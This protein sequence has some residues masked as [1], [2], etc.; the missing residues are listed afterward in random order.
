MPVNTQHKLYQKHIRKWTTVRDC[1]D[2]QDAIKEKGTAYLPRSAAHS[3]IEYE[4]YKERAAFFDGTSRTAEGLH[5]HLFAEDPVQSGEISDAFKEKLKNIDASGTSLDQF[6]SNIC[7]DAM[8]APW[9]GVLVDHIPVPE[10]STL[11]DVSGG[12]FLKWYPAESLINWNHSTINGEK[13]LTMVVLREDIEEKKPDDEFAMDTIEAYRV[14]SLD[15]DGYYNQ[16][17]FRKAE[18]AQDKNA[19]FV[20]TSIIYPKMSG[21][22]FKYIPFY[23]CPGEIPEKSM[24]LGLAYENIGYYQKTAEYENGLYFTS[25]PT[26]IVENMK[27]PCEEVE[28]K[29]KED[30]VEKTKKEK[31]YKKVT[32]GGSKFLFFYQEDK[33]GKSADVRVKFLEFDGAGL[34]EIAKALNS[35]LDRMAKLGI[36]AIGADKKGVET[37][38]VAQIHRASEHGVLGA[39]ARNMSEKITQAVRLKMT[40]DK[41]P[42][43]EASGWTY[44][45]PTKFNIEELTAQIFQIM[46]SARMANEIPRSVFFNYLKRNGML[47][48]GVETLEDF[49]NEL[50]KDLTDGHGTPS[51]EEGEQQQK[52]MGEK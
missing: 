6:V 8:Q 2:G 37:A 48:K 44:E 29:Y 52:T 16:R 25:V 47:P 5:G 10:G 20:Q 1:V 24:L 40:W 17:V 26:P 22:K 34:G 50:D 9:G 49:I 33:E 14:L 7:W 38:E 43:D 3:K 35:C 21:D 23:T 46:Y 42:E 13:K 18:N 4:N 12:A 11:A 15:A 31:V 32:T 36:Q 45:L 39:F 28:V 51:D 30:G 41:S 19:L 27:A